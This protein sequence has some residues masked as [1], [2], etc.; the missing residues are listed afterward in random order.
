MMN[1]P[2]YTKLLLLIKISLTQHYFQKAI[3]KSMV[4]INLVNNYTNK[5]KAAL[6]A[7]FLFINSCFNLNL[8][9]DNLK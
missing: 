2:D 4:D 3:E 7:V 6:K 5:Q 1:Q 9:A 8:F